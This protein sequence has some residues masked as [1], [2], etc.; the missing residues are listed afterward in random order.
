MVSI[1][2]IAGSRYPYFWFGSNPTKLLT[3]F[4]N[5]GGEEQDGLPSWILWKLFG[6]SGGFKPSSPN[7]V[8]SGGVGGASEHLL[9]LGG[10]GLGDRLVMPFSVAWSRALFGVVAD[11]WTSEDGGGVSGN[12]FWWGIEE[13]VIGLYMTGKALR[14]GE[15]R[16]VLTASKVRGQVKRCGLRDL[17][18]LYVLRK[19]LLLWYQKTWC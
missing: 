16:G 2:H 11:V 12:R 5:V 17:A 8:Y 6:P 19:D 3:L 10:W 13:L 7:E 14:S 9:L 18:C 4:M 15:P 1:P